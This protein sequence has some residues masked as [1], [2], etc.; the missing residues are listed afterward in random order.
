MTIMTEQAEAWQAIKATA[1]PVA[2]DAI[3][4]LET[5]PRELGAIY[6]ENPRRCTAG[7]PIHWVEAA[8]PYDDHDEHGAWY[9][10]HI[11][12]ALTCTATGDDG[13]V[14]AVAK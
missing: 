9:H 3:F 1:P 8:C 13:H 10:D 5:G 14:K 2:A 11:A 6:A 12:D 4:G 7:H